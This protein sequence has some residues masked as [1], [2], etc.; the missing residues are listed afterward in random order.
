[1]GIDVYSYTHKG[2]NGMT[3]ILAIFRSRTQTM[4]FVD[5]MR[6]RGVRCDAVPTPLEARVGCGLSAKFSP[7]DLPMARAII[8]YYRLNVFLG[9]YELKRIAGGT[10]VKK[11]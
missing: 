6:R 9:F 7:C 8:N 11:I 5:E 10:V 2:G 1:M 4:R 3:L